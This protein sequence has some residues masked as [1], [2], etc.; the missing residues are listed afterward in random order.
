MRDKLSVCVFVV[1]LLLQSLACAQEAEDTAA[2]GIEGGHTSELFDMI[3]AMHAGATVQDHAAVASVWLKCSK[4]MQRPDMRPHKHVDTGY[5]DRM[6]SWRLILR[7]LKQFAETKLIAMR[8]NLE[9]GHLDQ[10]ID[11][12]G[13]LRKLAV[14]MA[15]GSPLF[16]H[17]GQKILEAC[18]ALEKEFLHRVFQK[19]K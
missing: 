11:L 3:V 8:E 6:V 12:G 2:A 19:K 17:E 1:V 10:T 4:I 14:S 15:I 7:S 18:D 5:R 16:R 13:E 9:V